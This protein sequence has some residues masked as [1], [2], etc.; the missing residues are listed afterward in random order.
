MLGGRLPISGEGVEPE[1]AA[2]SAGGG[3]A[4]ADAELAE[5][6]R[7]VVVDGLDRDHQPGGDLVVA[8]ALARG[9]RAPRSRAGSARRGARGCVA[10]APAGTE[11]TPSR[12][13]SRRHSRAAASAPE[14]LEAGQ[15]LA[16]RAPPCR[17]RTARA[18]PPTGRAATPRPG[19]RPRAR[20]RRESRAGSGSGVD[21]DVDRLAETTQPGRHQPAPPAVHL[22]RRPAARA[23]GRRTAASVS[24]RSQWISARSGSVIPSQ[25]ASPVSVADSTVASRCCRRLRVAPP[26]EQPAEGLVGRDRVG[27]REVGLGEDLRLIDS[28][29]SQWPRSSSTAAWPPRRQLP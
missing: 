15:R 17:R 28:A 4:R 19:P 7:H 22:R 8:Q 9:G 5:H 29:S 3:A 25:P 10:R 1:A 24:P 26:A 14:R 13:S 18:P 16:Q 11:R 12:R 21:V 20:P 27:G 2:A 23:G 6:R